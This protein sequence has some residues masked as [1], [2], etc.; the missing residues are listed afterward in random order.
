MYMYGQSETIEELY[1][2][3]DLE[4]DMKSETIYTIVTCTWKID[5]NK[6][7]VMRWHVSHTTRLPIFVHID[8]IQ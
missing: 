8:Y 2:T 7:L 1:N 6:H 3:Q 4:T 5:E